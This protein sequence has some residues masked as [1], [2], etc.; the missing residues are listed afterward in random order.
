MAIKNVQNNI[1]RHARYSDLYN[2]F[3]PYLAPV[4]VKEMAI[5]SNIARTYIELLGTVLLP[6]LISSMLDNTATITYRVAN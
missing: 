6:Y 1:A 5:T 3:E 4:I 2:A